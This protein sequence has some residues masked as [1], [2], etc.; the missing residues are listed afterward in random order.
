[1][2]SVSIQ[3]ERKTRTACLRA[4]TVVIKASTALYPLKTSSDALE[5][6]DGVTMT[7]HT[8]QELDAQDPFPR[9]QIF[10]GQEGS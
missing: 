7:L 3:E 2:L 5:G 8:T 9:P 10:P 1:M 4:H 6:V